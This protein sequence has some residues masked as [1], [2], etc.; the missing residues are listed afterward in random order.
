MRGPRMHLPSP[1]WGGASHMTRRFLLP[2]PLWGGSPPRAARWGAPSPC[3]SAPPPPARPP[4]CSALR[5]GSPPSP[6]GGGQ[7]A[8]ASPTLLIIRSIVVKARFI[9]P[10]FCFG[11]RSPSLYSPSDKIRGVERRE[12]LPFSPRLAASRVRQ[13]RARL[14]ALHVRHFSIP[15]R[16]FRGIRA[17]ISQL[18]AGGSIVSPGRS[19]GPPGDRFTRPARRSRIPP[20]CNDVS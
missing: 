16:A 12:A 19:P 20:R 1:L 7:S 11:A 14:S 18:L 2:S 5:R 15:G 4:S 6:Q 10:G 9:A 8:Y 3:T 17:P 13:R